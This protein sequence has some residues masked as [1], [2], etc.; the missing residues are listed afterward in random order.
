MKKIIILGLASSLCIGSF[1]S[2]QTGAMPPSRMATTTP[3]RPMKDLNRRHM[4][5]V[6][7]FNQK[8]QEER[9]DKQK[10]IRDSRM[11]TK[12]GIRKDRVDLHVRIHEMRRD[13]RSGTTTPD[14]RKELHQNMMMERKE[15]QEGRHEDW[16]E[17]FELAK[18]R[19]MD[20]K[21]KIMGERAKL[22]DKLKVIKDERKKL[23][24]ER[25]GSR[26]EE[27]HDKSLDHFN[28]ALERLDGVLDKV[29]TR[30]DK[31]AVNG[32]DVAQVE[33]A[34]TTARGLIDA[35]KK[36]VADAAS[37]TYLITVTTEANLG[38]VVSA[39]RKSLYD[40]LKVLHNAVHDA[41]EAT[42]TALEALKAIPGIND[43]PS[44]AL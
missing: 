13:F 6:S 37:K 35:A 12:A 17:H 7:D 8:K 27:V 16:K 9:R 36:L 5:A 3:P 22:K 4:D 29:D 40:D 44:T 14:R 19:R 24:V 38:S 39:T 25:V 1:A 41:R 30:A 26:L 2:A 34:V 20:A 31:A 15:F 33:T 32:K 11:E 28:N 42:Q 21:E 43:E 23:T 18:D 10:D